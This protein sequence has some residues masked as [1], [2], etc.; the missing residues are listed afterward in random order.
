LPKNLPKKLLKYD[1]L[2]QI[3]NK[4]T[5]QRGFLLPHRHDISIICCYKTT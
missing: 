4:L 5:S 1:A 2:D 3:H